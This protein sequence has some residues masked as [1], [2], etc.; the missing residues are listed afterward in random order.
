MPKTLTARAR[1][2]ARPEGAQRKP[3]Q[4]RA[5]PRVAGQMCPMLIRPLAS[6]HYHVHSGCRASRSG[7]LGCALPRLPAGS[8]G[9]RTRV[10]CSG[11]GWPVVEVRYL[12]TMINGV[13]VITAPAEIDITTAGQLRAVLLAATENRCRTLVVDMTRTQFCDCAA[14]HALAA[15][16][17]RLLSAGGELRLV[18]LADGIVRRVLTLLDIDQFIHCFASLEEAVASASDG[19]HRTRQGTASQLPS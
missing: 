12:R 17:K 14:A 19:A 10:S 6:G 9:S 16:H 1:P 5:E 7:S 3:R 8:P 2:Q 15:A 18:V 11:G 13:P 4:L